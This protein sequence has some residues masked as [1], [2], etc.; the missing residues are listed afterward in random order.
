MQ[1]AQ[2]GGLLSLAHVDTIQQN[3]RAGAAQGLALTY[4]LPAKGRRDYK[5]I[6]GRVNQRRRI[7]M[8]TVDWN[9]TAAL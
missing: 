9:G 6:S 2:A 7:D 1:I 4:G 3:V 8:V 5:S